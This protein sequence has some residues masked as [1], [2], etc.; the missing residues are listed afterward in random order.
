MNKLIG[1]RQSISAV[2]ILCVFVQ[3]YVCVY[4][5][6]VCTNSRGDYYQE[7]YTTHQGNPFLPPWEYIPDAEPYVFED[8]I[9]PAS[10]VY[11]YTV[12]TI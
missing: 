8:P 12:L 7:I 3:Y 6:C 4:C 1:K 11:I 10:T 5:T 2:F 9:I